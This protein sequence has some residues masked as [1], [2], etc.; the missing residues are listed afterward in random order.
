MKKTCVTSGETFIAGMKKFQ[1]FCICEKLCSSV[2]LFAYM[3][4]LRLF[5]ENDLKQINNSKIFKKL[6]DFIVA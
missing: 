3:Q 4:Q 2:L 6:V 1:R 5:W